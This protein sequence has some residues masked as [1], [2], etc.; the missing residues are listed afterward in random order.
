MNSLSFPSFIFVQLG[1][2]VRGVVEGPFL[3]KRGEMY[4]LLLGSPHL[5]FRK[6]DH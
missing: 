3:V 1:S 6:H 4:Y 2:A 5:E